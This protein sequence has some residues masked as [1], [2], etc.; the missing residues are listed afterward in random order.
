LAECCIIN[1]EKTYGCEVEIPV[2]IRKD[3]SLFSESQSRIIISI[4]P[5]KQSVVESELKSLSQSFKLLGKVKGKTLRIN[6][7]FE[8]NLTELS[9]IYYKTIPRI[10]GSEE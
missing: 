9:E 2:K 7:Y 3:F 10:M 4:H 8:I 6:D 5:G 1:Q